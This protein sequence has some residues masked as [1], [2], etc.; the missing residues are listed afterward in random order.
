MKVIYDHEQ[1]ET[2]RW[3]N[4]VFLIAY[5]L[6]FLV[7]NLMVAAA[8]Q[9]SVYPQD[10]GFILQAFVVALGFPALV[11]LITSALRLSKTLSQMFKHKKLKRGHLL[12]GLAGFSFALNLVNL[13]L[14][15]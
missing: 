4:V 1:A 15:V 8:I 10:E 9:I 3:V 6:V 7:C 2:P 5:G 12:V 11:G 14:L 13:V